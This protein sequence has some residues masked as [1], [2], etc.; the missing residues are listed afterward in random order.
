VK[1]PTR[2]RRIGWSRNAARPPGHKTNLGHS[3]QA[4]CP[5]RSTDRTVAHAF[6]VGAQW[7]IATIINA[8][9]RGDVSDVLTAVPDYI[10]EVAHGNW[11]PT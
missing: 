8:I 10:N 2:E 6:M 11:T 1:S 4:R 5:V 9:S 3:G 7:S